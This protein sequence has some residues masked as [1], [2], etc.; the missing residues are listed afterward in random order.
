MGASV[1][2]RLVEQAMAAME[3]PNF[4]PV[5][6]K[7]NQTL[8]GMDVVMDATI[9]PGEVHL[10]GYRLES[11]GSRTP[12]TVIITSIIQS[13]AAMEIPDDALRSIP[14]SEV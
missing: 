3:S 6:A 1:D 13:T 4:D 8:L 9:P 10:I 7:M 2:D 14:S 12:I 11:N 5:A